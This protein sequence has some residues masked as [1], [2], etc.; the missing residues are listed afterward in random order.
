[1]RIQSV[2]MSITI[3]VLAVTVS[4]DEAEISR[5]TECLASPD[6]AT[7][8]QAADA[9]G[10][11]GGEAQAAVPAL[12]KALNHEDSEVCWHICRAL[13][14]IGGGDEAAVTA[15]AKVLADENPNVRAYAAFALGRM[16][17]AGMPAVDALLQA[18]FDPEPL[19]RRA[20][21]RAIRAIDPPQEKTLPVVMKILDEGDPAVIM[22]ALS[23]LAEE[24]KDAVP[25]LRNALK[26]ERASY[27]ACIVLAEIG[28]DAAEAVPDIQAVLA[29]ADP[30]ARMQALLALGEI[31][32]ASAPAV[33]KIIELL[34][35][36]QFPPIQTA[37]AYALVKI[38]ADG[39][40]DDQALEKMI[41]SDNPFLKLISAWGFANMNPDNKAAVRRAMELIMA[42]LESDDDILKSG[43]A[44][45]LAEFPTEG[46]DEAVAALVEVLDESDPYVIG[47]AIDA[48]AA[49]GPKALNG[50]GGALTRPELRNYA[51]RIVYRMGPEAAQAVPALIEV[52]K[53]TPENDDD[54]A[55]RQEV[56]LALAAIGPA[57]LPAMPQLVASLSSEDEEVR[58]SACY[59]LGKIGPQAQSAATQPLDALAR[60]GDIRTRRAAIWALLKIRPNDT[61]LQNLAVP[62]LTQG[63]ESD[64]ELVRYEAA[65]TL[66]DL[67]E[68]AKSAIE[69]LRKLLEDEVPAVRVAATEA[70]KKLE[71]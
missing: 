48:L 29:H 50:I 40:A 32:P 39:D 34:E 70:L 9:L 13:G 1:M 23:T 2:L 43:A 64:R 21:G 65:I 25:R 54:L 36:S 59:A 22:P 17:K 30:D 63:L 10:D 67:G 26:H 33:P 41:D 37:A 20:A 5:L 38:N 7:C 45:A 71:N 44:R 46:S 35:E 8:L 4:A 51:I 55:F 6:K 42:A 27:W 66:G 52:L 57:A 47:N 18:S 53:Q 12:V 14:T 56:Q 11:L 19:V 61:R 15:L 16:G 31:G 28:P 68:V 69:P 49:L 62:L 60:S 3:L 58:G 24:G